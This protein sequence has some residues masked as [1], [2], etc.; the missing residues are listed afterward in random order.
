MIEQALF[1]LN[2]HPEVVVGPHEL[3][4]LV[5]GHVEVGVENFNFCHFFLVVNFSIWPSG[6]GGGSIYWVAL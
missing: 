3:H 4:E 1:F 2:L 5:D 6:A